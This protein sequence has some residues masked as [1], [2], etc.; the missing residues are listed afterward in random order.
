MM[1]HLF[2]LMIRRPPRST[3]FPYTTLFQS[4]MPRSPVAVAGPAARHRT[5]VPTTATPSEGAGDGWT[6]TATWMVPALGIPPV[7]A[8]GRVDPDEREQFLSWSALRD[9]AIRAPRD[10][11]ALIHQTSA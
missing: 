2:F 9:R 8:C 3:L 7:D 10:V 5:S 4:Q 6:L 1:R 11:P